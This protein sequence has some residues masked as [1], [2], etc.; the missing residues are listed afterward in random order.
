[1]SYQTQTDASIVRFHRK[2]KSECWQLS[3]GIFFSKPCVLV[4]RTAHAPSTTSWRRTTRPFQGFPS[5]GG[6]H[7][8]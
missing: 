1:M 7:H 5:L 8:F 6:S 3:D 2:T 4:H